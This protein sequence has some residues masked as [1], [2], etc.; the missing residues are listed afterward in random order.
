MDAKRYLIIAGLVATLGA[1]AISSQVVGAAPA[2]AVHTTQAA[3][4][5]ASGLTLIADTQAGALQARPER[6]G[7]SPLAIVAEKLGLTEDALRA[8]LAKNQSVA[9]VAAARNVSVSSLVDAVV[10]DTAPHLAQAVQE[11]HLT[12]AE[13]DA[14]LA[15]LKTRLTAEFNQPGLPQRGDERRGPGGPGGRGPGGR[16]RPAPPTT[17]Q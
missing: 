3:A 13:A 5:P 15:E 8:E 6:D 14:R 12:Q 10:A 9:Q 17:D 16:E 4:A 11:G 1:G 7:A 2:P